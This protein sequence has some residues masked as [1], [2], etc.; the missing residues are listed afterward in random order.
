LRDLGIKGLRDLG[1]EGFWEY[2]MVEMGSLEWWSRI[3]GEL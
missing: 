1:I 2:L 3:L